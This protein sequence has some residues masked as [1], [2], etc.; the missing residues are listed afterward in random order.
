MDEGTH[1]IGLIS[2]THGLVRPDVF[3]ALDGVELILHAG[4]VGD[5]V[6]AELSAIAP[7]DAVYGNTDPTDDPRL[8]QSIERMIAG[9]R[10]HVSHGHELGS[11]TPERLLAKYDADVIV[12]GHTHQ[13]KIVDLGGRLVVNPGAAGQRR[14]RLMPSVGV[15]TIARGVASVR[16]IDLRVD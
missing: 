16:I 2:D 14:F 13:Q 1:H 4:D 11:P 10:V 15:L 5:G 6:L 8:R 3:S 12:Y 7:V 9:V